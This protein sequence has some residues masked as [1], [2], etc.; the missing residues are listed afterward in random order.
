[1]AVPSP[2][3]SVLIPAYNEEHGLALTVQLVLAKLDEL[4]VSAEILLVNDCSRDRTGAV[5][6]ALAAG[7]PRIRAFHHA[8]NQGIGGGFVTGTQQAHGEWL[9]LIPADLAIDLDELHKYTDVAPKADVVVGVCDVTSR[10]DYSLFRRLVHYV[11]IG[12]I[13]TLFRV[14][15][16]QFQYICLYRVDFL[17]SIRLE[18]V[19]SAFVHAEIILKAHLLGKRL[20]EVDTHYV[21]RATGRATGARWK[22]IFFTMRDMTHFWWR[23][24]L[25][26]AA[27][28][29][30]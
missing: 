13:Q 27:V 16:R 2:T 8:T 3:L 14:T 10:A 20:T 6:D 5:A 1:M 21:P 22:A 24:R 29:Q 9:I 30:R 25:R 7:D 23:W 19:N 26:G 12:L 18:Y 28:A 17:R 15:Y 4:G 11:N